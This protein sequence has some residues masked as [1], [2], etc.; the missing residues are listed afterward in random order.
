MVIISLIVA[1]VVAALIVTAKGL[2]YGVEPGPE[3]YVMPVVIGLTTGFV[4]YASANLIEGSIFLAPI[5]MV[6]MIGFVVWLVKWWVTDGGR[7][8]EMVPFVILVVL[9][10]L[11]MK[12]SAYA[13]SSVIGIPLVASLVNL[14]PWF[15]AIIAVFMMVCDYLKFLYLEMD[16]N[17][18][19]KK[20]HKGLG[21]LAVAVMAI[22]IATTL[23]T[24]VDWALTSAADISK[25]KAGDTSVEE[26]DDSAMEPSELVIVDQNEDQTSD[27]NGFYFYNS[28]L[29]DDQD[30]SN[31]FNFGFNPGSLTAAEFDA[32]FR[33][34][35]RH[36]PALGAAD[37]AW[38]DANLGTRYLGEF[39]ESCKGDWAKTIN[40][41]KQ[42]FIKDPALYSKT[43]DAFFKMLDKAKVS[44]TSGNDLDD[45][46]YMNPYTVDGIP[47]VI[48]MV[49][50]D[51][52][53]TFLTYTFIIKG[54]GEVNVSYRTEC[55]Y[56]PTNVE[57][58][59]KITPQEKPSKP[60][61]KGGKGD[62]PSKP[63][64]PSKPTKPSYNKDPNKAPKKNTEKNDDKGPGPN[65]NNPSNPNK[66]SKDTKDS[67]SSG[68]YEDYK[69]GVK[70]KKD[71]NKSQKT[72]SDSNT[73]STPTPKP[74]TNVDN[75]G[76]K[77]T[78][79]GGANTP[80]PTQPKAKEADTGKEINNSPGEAWGGP[81]D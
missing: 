43:L 7:W 67:S 27:N 17:D 44:V 52:V 5:F 10:C 80:T 49:T 77:G 66:S 46:M 45:Q 74:N 62:K 20:T 8:V 12:A 55:G 16:D 78:G 81:S 63:S 34:R 65:T 28:E 41:S 48:V 23:G 4:N 72:G 22:M 35:L 33:E 50:P 32:D 11:V 30:E 40:A 1:V 42:V 47:D 3:K 38:A 29:Q 2:V 36:D 71:T 26:I 21:W 79:N 31:D 58:V 76:D 19:Q 9:F 59:M 57:R 68:S 18:T 61:K 13:F 64:K 51:H 6:V 24:G 15:T 69:K 60:G 54:T 73:P 14:V 37:M 70:E 75:N 25:A 56:Q 39:Y 53:G